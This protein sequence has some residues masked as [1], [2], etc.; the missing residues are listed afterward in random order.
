M[1]FATTAKRQFLIR[2]LRAKD[3]QTDSLSQAVSI[4]EPEQ[5]V[6]LST[7]GFAATAKCQF[8][9]SRPLY[10]GVSNGFLSQASLISE[11]AQLTS[12]P[13]RGLCYHHG[14]NANLSALFTSNAPVQ[15]LSNGF[16]TQAVVISEPAQL[17]AFPLGV[18]CPI[19]AKRQFRG[20]IRG[21]ITNAKRVKRIIHASRLYHPHAIAR[22]TRRVFCPYHGK[23]PAVPLHP[24][25][26]RQRKSGSNAL[27]KQAAFIV[28]SQSLAL[29]SVSFATITAKT[30]TYHKT[31][32]KDCQPLFQLFAQTDYPNKPCVSPPTQLPSLSI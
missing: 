7:W 31:P 21:I 26:N 27:S 12:L 5:L 30:P 1:S 9:I 25:H 2:R 32:H 6:S 14:K 13:L 20:C 3:Y 16:A 15:R 10:K 11:P 8:L 18:F 24:W 23:T 4:N 17:P 29:S 19:T 28:P 22:F